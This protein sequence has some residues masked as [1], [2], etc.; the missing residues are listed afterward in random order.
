M[1]SEQDN[2][3]IEAIL[4]AQ[5]REREALLSVLHAVHARYRYV[6]P[7]ALEYVADHSAMPLAQLAGVVTFYPHFRLRPA[8]RHRIRLCDGTAC[9]VKGAE[10]LL[11]AL[12]RYLRLEEGADT[13]AAG[14]FTVEKVACL[15]C[16]TLAPVMQVDGVVYGHLTAAQL[17]GLLEDVA[18]QPV[19]PPAS[20]LP[21]AALGAWEG[22][23]QIGLGSCCQSRGSARVQAALA[24][25]VAAA[26][27]AARIKRVGCVGMCH[28]TPLVRVAI[29]GRPDALYARVAPEDAGAL[30]ARHFRGHRRALPLLRRSLSRWLEDLL[31][32]AAASGA[33]QTLAATDAPVAAFLA[34]QQRMATEGSEIM[35]PLD[36]DEYLAAGG[37]RE[38]R[39]CL[40]ENEPEQAIAAIALSGLR[41]RG[42]AGY[43]TGLKWRQVRAAAGTPKYVVCNGDEGDPGAYMDRMILES[44][45]YRVIEG[46]AIAAWA[47][48]AAKG[49]LYIRAEY[50]LAVARVREALQRCATAGI[51]GAAAPRLHLV[52]GGGAFVCGEET[53][54]LASLEG[55]RGMPRVRPP[56]PAE[57][58]LRDCPTLVNNVETL[59]LVPWILER[60]AAAFSALGT[61]ESKGA[62]VFALAGKVARGGLIEVPMGTTIRRIVAE[63][64]GGVGEG[65]TFKAVQIGGP[66]GGC[67]PAA[68]A[69]LRIDYEELTAAG[70]MMGSGGLVVLDDED[71][72]VEIARYFLEFT[73]GQSCGKCTF[74]RIGTRRMLDIL[75]RLCAGQGQSG[76]LDRLEALGRSVKAAS[77]CGLGRTAPNPV[78]TTLRY[79]RDEYEAHAQ[80]RCP[81][82]KCRALIRYTVS[83]KC[84]GC[85]LC[86]QHCPAD[87]IP[88]TPYRRHRID[89]ARCIR[90]G[91][92]RT[93]CPEKAVAVESP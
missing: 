69:D 14:R 11:A 51:F 12:Q 38:Y 53:A 79:F 31:A 65:R 58:G 41:G 2:A 16:C 3:A 80:G 92:C 81:A 72:M 37:F 43:P 50:P 90:C 56:Y 39:R 85:T 78:L 84:I 36:L 47:V 86:A 27:A 6:P 22:E 5:G 74:C 17:P 25:A 21:V 87:A 18:A 77:L 9:H 88:M 75:N 46:L 48:G 35:D 7:E 28:Q 15:G 61:A 19:T 49:I 34:G 32:G 52:E 42:G 29:P 44:R 33:G 73:Q 23:I 55:R 76:D 59:A 40:A 20:G 71:C 64:G 24:A 62:K 66:S 30:V 4:A 83:D 68:L 67:L 89:A 8:G 45:P 91:T 10:N 60:G 26:G 1:W 82:G 54:L 57:R 63:I 13:D 93:V 70:A